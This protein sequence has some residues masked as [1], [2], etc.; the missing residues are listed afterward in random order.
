MVK[1]SFYLEQ[2]IFKY[3]KTSNKCQWAFASFIAQ[4]REFPP[5]SS[6]GEVQHCFLT[7]LPLTSTPFLWSAI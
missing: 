6:T 4:K 5:F 1:Y 3:R 2:N 7:E